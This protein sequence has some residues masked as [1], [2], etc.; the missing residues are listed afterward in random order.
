[1]A[2][3]GR[4]GHLYAPRRVLFEP[5]FS[6]NAQAFA[7]KYANFPQDTVIANLIRRIDEIAATQSDH[8]N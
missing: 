5:E 2:D 3:A 4:H 1:L 8:Q 6:L 7:R